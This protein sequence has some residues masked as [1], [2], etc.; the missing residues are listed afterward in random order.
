MSAKKIKRFSGDTY[1][2]TATLKENQKPVD[3]TGANVKMTIGY[4]PSETITGTILDAKKG[5]IKFDFTSITVTNVGIFQYDIQV[6]DASNIKTT[7]V[8]DSIEFI[9]DLTS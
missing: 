7:Y 3:L 4:T 2:I 8:R 1:P 5:K 9:Q 6:E